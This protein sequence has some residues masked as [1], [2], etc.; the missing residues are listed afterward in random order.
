MKILRK[1]SRWPAPLLLLLAL[2]FPCWAAPADQEERNLLVRLEG[3][4]RDSRTHQ[5]VAEAL[6][7]LER[8]RAQASLP[9]RS[10]EVTLSTVTAQRGRFQFDGIEPGMYTLVATKRGYVPS[11]FHVLELE[12]GKTTTRDVVL[13]P[14]AKV[15]GRVVDETDQG[16]EEAKVV[17]RIDLMQPSTA[18][19]RLLDEHGIAAL[20]TTTDGQ[21]KFELFVPAEEGK[22]TLFAGALGYASNRVGPLRV[23]AGRERNGVVVRLPPGLEVRGQVVNE[24]RAPL[25]EATVVARRLEP[26]REGL[27]LED[28]DPRATSGAEG[29][30]LLSGLEKGRYI[31]KVNHAT[32]AT[33]TRPEIEIDAA[34]S[35]IPEIVLVPQA[36]IGGW[37]T[38]TAGQPVA[39]AIVYG[40]R[41]G[42][43]SSAMVLSDDDGRFVLS[44]FPPG[45]RVYLRA[46]APGYTQGKEMVTTP[47]TDVVLVVRPHGVL[48]GRV[49]DSDTRAPLREFRIWMARGSEEKNFRSEDGSFEWQGLPPGRWNFI[50]QAPGYQKAELRE[51]EIRSGEPTEGVVFLLRRGVEL[52]G[53]VVD[54]ETGEALPNVTVGYH[55][56]SEPEDPAWLRFTRN[57]QTTDAEGNF[58]FEGV[59]SVKVTVIANSSLYAPARTTVMAGEEDFV[60][61][62]LGR[63]AS[64]SGRVLASDRVTPVPG[65]R[66]SLGS[67]ASG[68]GGIPT[69]GAGLFSFDR[70]S[71]GRYRLMAESKYGQTQPL[72]VVLRENEHL[73]GLT[74]VI[75]PGATLRGKVG[76]VL[77]SELPVVNLV[78]RGRGGFTVFTSTDADGAYVIH[79]VPA[80]VVQVMAS[81]SSFRS[82]RKSI[83]VPEGVQQLTLDIEFPR[84]ARLYGR[85][86]R[87]GQPVSF[88]SVIAS[89]VDPQLPRASGETDQD[90]M[91]S[92]DGLSDGDYVVRLWGEGTR[93][94]IRISGDT[95]LDIELSPSSVSGHVLEA[96]SG[97]PLPEARVQVRTVDDAGNTSGF[98]VAVTDTLGR[99]SIEGIEPGNYQVVAHKPGFRVSMETVSVRDSPLVQELILSLTRAEGIE[100]RV[101]DGISGLGLWTVSVNVFSGP[102]RLSMDV[103][104]D[105]AG[106]GRLPQL[107]SGRYDLVISASGY[108]AKTLIGWTVPGSPL[109]LYLTPGGRLEIQVDSAY[110]G[111]KASLLD[112][113]GI[114]ARPA[115]DPFTLS[116][117]TVLP[118]L[119]PGEYTLLVRLPNETKIYKTTVFEGKAT[120][121]HVK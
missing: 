17:V 72:D 32:H 46:E 120:F 50:A 95:T 48:R 84:A 30:F 2:C 52:T 60:E 73:A 4:V 42:E 19:R 14:L 64:L 80:G 93:R 55:D 38:D 76:G 35:E 21:G 62:R 67:V 13:D 56:A 109:D 57:K 45:T 39:G 101:R 23:E 92:I 40:G 25:S 106:K 15:S 86:T 88:A 37:V 111:V 53:R 20:T 1:A 24:W 118:H 90:G 16:V 112:A 9:A 74:L 69:D 18:L 75:K 100:I 117:P 114:P 104:L 22:V 11:S 34:T 105:E 79:G 82:V 10:R 51:V 99:F 27:G 58:K 89:P 103:A 5:P 78:A 94:S 113:N 54:D 91:Y 26:G 61:I 47:Q 43:E 70:L 87:A 71:A 3:I 59:P 119:S 66:V 31:L 81:T 33:R 115:S 107:P 12:P 8:G 68:S 102:V 85:V 7:S 29:S 36:E 49:E 116:Q 28:I 110:I 63:G 77:P 97:E 98:A 65:A 96:I 108:A 121:L 6:V 83:E 41:A 44:G